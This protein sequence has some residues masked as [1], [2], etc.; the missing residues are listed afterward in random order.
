MADHT[1]E[2]ALT[3]EV[4]SDL[5]QLHARTSQGVW[6]QGA[7]SHNTI[8][9]REGQPYYRIA[10]FHHADDASFVD[11][12]HKYMP[13]LIAALQWQA[14]QQKGEADPLDMPLPCDITVGHVTMSKGVPLRSLVFRMKALY[15]LAQEA[16]SPHGVPPGYVLVPAEVVEFLKGAAALDGAWFGERHRTE[17]GAFWWRKRLSSLPQAPQG[18]Q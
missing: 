5:L 14:E 16:A 8:A 2:E 17:R 3:P 11:A 7:T 13:L 18:E 15:E 4:L 1:T 12:A 9:K 10:D 6:G